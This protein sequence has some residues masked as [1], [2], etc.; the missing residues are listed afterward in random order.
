M[1]R[2]RRTTGVV[3]GLLALALVG[4]CLAPAPGAGGGGHGGGC[5]QGRACVDVRF[6]WMDGFDDPATPDE[7][8]R[9]GVLQVGPRSARN[10]L[11]LN[12]GTSA[13]AGYF[14]PLAEDIVR[15]T[16]GRW[17]VWSVERREDQPED[18]AMGG[19]DKRG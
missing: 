8:D 12:P 5:R 1:R 4:G 16:R 2:V 15:Q 7:M 19:R 6:T 10:V 11:V 13:G 17:Q 9:V 14:R 3:V 18:Q